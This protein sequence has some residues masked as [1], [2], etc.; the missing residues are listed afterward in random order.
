MKTV[1]V[2]GLVA[3]ICLIAMVTGCASG[4]TV[5]LTED[6]KAPGSA[7]VQ[8]A[9]AVGTTGDD[10][11]PVPKEKAA[12]LEKYPELISSL[13]SEDYQSAESYVH[14][15]LIQQKKE[16]A[17]DIEDYLVTVDLNSENFEDFFEFETVPRN[18]AF[19]E[20]EDSMGIGVKSKKY[21]EGLIVYSLDDITVEYTFNSF[22]SEYDLKELLSFGLSSSFTADD[23]N[24]LSYTGRI[25]NG[26]V[27]YIKQE[28]VEDYPVSEL[29]KP[30]DWAVETTIQLKNGE[31]I[32][33]YL[34]PEYPY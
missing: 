24:V 12:I 10:M 6:D 21:D 4:N 23:D 15:L 1:A 31:T 20:P 7:T 17:G 26:T 27:T 9:S 25:T 11:V 30:D 18:N 8:E 2:R 32:N 22:D 13:E 19:G 28:Y 5:A 33:R 16:A 14:E 29:K 3:G 34:Y